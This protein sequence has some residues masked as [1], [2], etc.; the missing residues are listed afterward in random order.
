M[1]KYYAE[2][3]YP[4]TLFKADPLTHLSCSLQLHIVSGVL[5]VMGL[6]GCRNAADTTSDSSAKSNSNDQR[7]HRFTTIP[8]PQPSNP[9]S[10]ETSLSP[11][12]PTQRW[13]FPRIMAGG[14]GIAD[15][16]GDGRPDLIHTGLS[17]AVSPEQAT[18]LVQVLRQLESGEF[19]DVSARAALSFNG[20]PGGVAIADFTND[21][22]PD[23]CLT[24]AGDCRLYQN[25]GDFRFENLTGKTEIHGGRWSTSAAFLDFDRDGWL[26][27]F[28]ANY[29]DY[30][31]A[32][33]CPDASG[34]LDFCSPSVFPRTTDRLYRNQAGYTVSERSN[35]PAPQPLFADI[36]AAS[37]IASQ[38]GAGLGVAAADWN[39]D[40]WTDI[41][42]ANDGHANV[43]WI[44]QRDGHFLDEAVLRGVAWDSAG[45]SQGSMG[46]AVA[47]LDDNGHPDLVVTNLDGE[48]NTVCISD[49]R[50][51]R[52]LSTQWQ[53]AALSWAL[54]GFGTAL[55]DLDHDAFADFVA[56]NGRVRRHA[57]T[58]PEEHTPSATPASDFWTGYRERQLVLSGKDQQFSPFQGKDK[59]S[60]LEAVGRGLAVGD[61]DTDGDL[62]LFFT[63]LDR[64][65]V[66]FRNDFAS[67]HWLIAQPQ[68][69]SAGNRPAIGSTVTLILDSRRLTGFLI[70]G[71]SY[72]SASEALVHFGLGTADRIRAIQVA[73]P[74]G[75][76]EEFPGGAVDRRLVLVQGTGQPAPDTAKK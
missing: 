13:Q 35:S 48:S 63:F 29:V 41:F 1:L 62:D 15:F 50:S 67:G 46:T 57:A 16:D 56:A 40:G 10:A 9:R 27:L 65:P 45:Q 26:D 31:P 53:M 30:D 12:N 58:T 34:R 68:I 28:V 42:V 23:L 5:L 55:P 75:S 76:V 64:G 24:G 33:D 52:D 4:S 11:L 38:R 25:L 72:Q 6:I 73:W 70:G 59:L 7:T 19:E 20:I 44:N 36:S 74:D 47:D 60:E 69:P 32:H 54:T 39:G 8:L 14:C 17:P 21:G 71:G 51:F 3:S 66:L 18:P 22:R 43:L 2:N 37:G 61:I 49:G